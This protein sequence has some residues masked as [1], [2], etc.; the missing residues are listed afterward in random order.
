MV[1]PDV[2]PA[3]YLLLIDSSQSMS[4]RIDFVKEAARRLTGYLRPE[5]RV[6]VVPFS[7]RLGPVTG[8]T[9]DHKTVWPRRPQVISP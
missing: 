7:R 1:R 4:R 6:I 3:T 5:D 2:L 9:A 8:P